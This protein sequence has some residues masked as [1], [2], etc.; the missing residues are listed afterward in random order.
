MSRKRTTMAAVAFGVAVSSIL[1]LSSKAGAHH[2][3]GA[4]DANTTLNLSGV[5][6]ESSYAN[7][8]GQVRLQ[9]A[10]DGGRTWLV[11][12][13]PPSRMNSRGLSQ[14]MLRVGAT[15]TVVGYPH[16][17]NKDEMRAERITVE[18]KTVELR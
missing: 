14:E 9:V 15:L 7:P 13:A 10:G 8:H 3:W 6:L 18:E 2:G 17:E 12:L 4:Y 11:V 5:I 1:F 16:R